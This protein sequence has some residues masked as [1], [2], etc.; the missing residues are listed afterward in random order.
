MIWLWPTLAVLLS[1]V[2]LKFA[3]VALF[4]DDWRRD[5]TTNE[6]TWGDEPGA[7]LPTYRSDLPPAELANHVI[8]VAGKLPR[9]RLAKLEEGDGEV[10]IRFVRSTRLLRFQDDIFVR[11]ATAGEGSSLWASSK[12]RLGKGDLGQ[13]PRNLRELHAA[14]EESPVGSA[15]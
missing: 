10:A 9:W 11:I 5:L 2:V 14:L 13:N 4:V 7:V 8:A 6:A 1:I 12:S 15:R 3:I